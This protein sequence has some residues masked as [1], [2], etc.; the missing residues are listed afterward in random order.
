MRSK[1]CRNEIVGKDGKPQFASGTSGVSVYLVRKD[2]EQVPRRNLFFLPV[3]EDGQGSGHNI[4]DL[5]VLVYML[6]AVKAGAKTAAESVI[7]FGI[8]L[9]IL[10]HFSKITLLFGYIIFF[11]CFIV[12]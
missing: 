11:F 7:F 10:D 6:A 8:L 5:G 2:K 1:E 3:D 12:K 4:Y 9:L